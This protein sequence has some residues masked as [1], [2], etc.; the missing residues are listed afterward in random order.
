MGKTDL[1]AISLGVEQPHLKSSGENKSSF[2][3]DLKWGPKTGGEMQGE[4][5]IT[6]TNMYKRHGT[7]L[8]ISEVL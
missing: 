2:A 7:N 6:M 1:E 5:E 3:Q 8:D 4:L